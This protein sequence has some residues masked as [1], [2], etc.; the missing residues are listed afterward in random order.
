MD[1]GRRDLGRRSRRIISRLECFNRGAIKDGG[2]RAR[3]LRV[4]AM[5]ALDQLVGGGREICERD[6]RVLIR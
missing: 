5:V 6:P 3:S 4:T 1:G 2:R